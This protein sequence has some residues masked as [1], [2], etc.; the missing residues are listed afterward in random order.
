[1]SATRIKKIWVVGPGLSMGGIERASSTIANS[2]SDAGY[3]V[4]YLAI[5]KHSRFFRLNDNV[6]FIEP[7]NFNVSKL[8]FFKTI[9]WIKTIVRKHRPDAIIVF[10]YFLG[11]LVRISVPGKSVPFYVSDRASPLFKWPLKVRLINKIVFALFPPTGIIAQTEIAAIKKR[12]EFGSEVEVRI[13]PNAVRKVVLFPD[14]ERKPQIVAVG[15]LNDHLKGFDRLIE[16][17]A[18]LDKTNWTLVFAGG[19]GISEGAGLA[20]KV[21]EYGLKDRVRFLGKVKNIDEVFAESSIFVIPSRSEGFPNALCEAMAS[22]LACVSFD[23]IAGPR[24][25]IDDNIN[26][27]IVEDGNINLL[28]EKMCCLIENER[29]RTDLGMNA[30]SISDKLNPEIIAK[31]YIDFIDHE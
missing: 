14:I 5:F 19:D 17:F 15:R 9:I 13:I 24:D 31:K 22:G 20:A 4:S 1:M 26:G 2:L 6:D 7:E 18:L 12:K 8:S 11:A 28:A 25:I 10:N 3:M 29:L 21:I 23:F 30:M 16:A 27:L